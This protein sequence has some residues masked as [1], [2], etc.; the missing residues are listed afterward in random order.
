[1]DKKPRYKKRFKKKER[2]PTEYQL[3]RAALDE[4]PRRRKM[5]TRSTRYHVV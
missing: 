3:E 2:K 5:V 4:Q 1:M